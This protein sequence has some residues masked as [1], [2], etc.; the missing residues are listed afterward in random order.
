MKPTIPQT[1]LMNQIYQN[2]AKTKLGSKGPAFHDSI[3]RELRI[4]DEADHIQRFSWYNLPKGMDSD[5]IERVLY[6]RGQGLFF[7]NE[8][9]ERFYFLPFVGM[10]IDVYGR[11]LEAKPLP[12]NGTSA[13]KDELPIYGEKTW[14]V[15]NEIVPPEDIDLEKFVNGA[16]ILTDYSKQRAQRVLSRQELTEPLLQMMSECLPMARTALINGTG[17]LGYRVSTADDAAEVGR[18]SNACANAALNGDRWIPINQNGL[19]QDELGTPSGRSVQD[20]LLAMQSMDNLRLSFLGLENGG[21]F[22]KQAHLLQTE[23]NLNASKSGRVLQNGL[24]QR[25]DFC[26]K[27]NA[28]WNL[29]IWCEISE[30]ALDMDKNMDGVVEDNKA[31]MPLQEKEG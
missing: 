25:I 10:G 12:F 2:V 3:L 13:D 18:A 4:M 17:I 8:G 15:I 24:A 20:Y 7:Y 1:Q 9:T 14:Q 23:Q 30:S 28:L 22:G 11:F 19:P 26:N 5:L 29:G 16:V 6:Y 21:I 27:V 31:A